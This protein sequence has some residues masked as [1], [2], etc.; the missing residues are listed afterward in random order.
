MTFENF[1]RDENKNKW[2]AIRFLESRCT[3]EYDGQ[4]LLWFRK[5]VN[6]M[7]PRVRFPKDANMH[8]EDGIVENWLKSAA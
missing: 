7:R 3:I 2:V 5:A 8:F 4:Y 1:E 6:S